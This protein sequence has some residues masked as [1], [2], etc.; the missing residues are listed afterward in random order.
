MKYATAALS[1]QFE[2]RYKFD[3]LIYNVRLKT[4]DDVTIFLD[5]GCFNTM[6]PVPIAERSGRSLGFKMPYS[7]G[8]RVIATE[9]FSIDK[10]QIGSFLLERIIAFAGEYPGEYE[11]DIILGANVINNWEMLI[12]KRAHK[13]QF[14][15]DPPDSLPNKTHIYQNYFNKAGNYVC[16]QTTE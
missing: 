1:N 3:A 15:E 4:F 16:V 10:L 6:I 8:G 11:D 13:F 9:A 2:H 5:S 7:I 12:N 14:R